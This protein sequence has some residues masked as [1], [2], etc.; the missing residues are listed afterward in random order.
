MAKGLGC[1]PKRLLIVGCQQGDV[2]ELGEQLTAPVARAV[3]V[4]VERIHEVLG[5]WTERG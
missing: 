3:S 5:D 4:A 1:L 2:E